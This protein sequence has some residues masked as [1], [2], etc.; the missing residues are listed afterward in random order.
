LV[1][2]LPKEIQNFLPTF[3]I[4]FQILKDANHYT[5]GQMSNWLF[6]ASQRARFGG[7]KVSYMLALEALN[8][9][10]D[11]RHFCLEPPKF[12]SCSTRAP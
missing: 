4:T 11:I 6:D 9:V 8:L 10:N 3:A 12:G 1:C 7:G 5:P 2:N